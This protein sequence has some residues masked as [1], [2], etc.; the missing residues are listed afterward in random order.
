M[1]RATVIR[2][3]GPR[4]VGLGR[5]ELQEH[6]RSFVSRHRWQP[7]TQPPTSVHLTTVPRS[8]PS[9]RHHGKGPPPPL[10]PTHRRRGLLPHPSAIQRGRVLQPHLS[11]TRRGRV[12]PPHPSA[13]S[14]A[15]GDHLPDSGTGSAASRLLTRRIRVRRRTSPPWGQ[16]SSPSTPQRTPQP[17]PSEPRP[18]AG[19]PRLGS[20]ASRTSPRHPRSPLSGLRFL[21]IGWRRGQLGD[22]T[23]LPSLRRPLRGIPRPLCSASALPRDLK[24]LPGILRPLPRPPRALP[25]IPRL[26][27]GARILPGAA[28]SQPGNLKLLADP[29]KP[30]LRDPRLLPDSRGSRPSGPRVLSGSH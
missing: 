17:G 22:L 8:G 29:L 25:G 20:S 28:R 9:A 7:R 11:G 5:R 14:G 19:S 18:L 4:P 16:Q 12:L 26:L 13:T 3:L 21:P 30:P 10:G 23:A 27:H 24:L 1:D 2:G 15:S 6:R